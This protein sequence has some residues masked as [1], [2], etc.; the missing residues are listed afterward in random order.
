MAKTK[1]SLNDH[2][3]E[4]ME[5]LGDRDIKGDELTEEINRAE[6]KCRVAQQI[7]VNA[8]LALSVAKAADSFNDPKTKLPK[9]LLDMSGDR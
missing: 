1:L 3:F 8:N 4:A 2:L 6:A 5:Y 7:L 9:M